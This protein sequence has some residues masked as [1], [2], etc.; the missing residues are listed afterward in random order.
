MQFLQSGGRKSKNQNLNTTEMS[1]MRELD[2]FLIED[3]IDSECCPLKWWKKHKDE[4]PRIAKVAKIFLGIPGSQSTSERIFSSAGG[5]VTEKR[6][7]LASSN[8][9]IL[10]FL[11]DNLTLED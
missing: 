4:F 8:V 6:T 11:H 5:I 9:G 2:L 1:M 3:T 7:C 10:G